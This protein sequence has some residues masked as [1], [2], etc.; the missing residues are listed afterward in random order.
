MQTFMFISRD[1]LFTIRWLYMIPAPF[2]LQKRIELSMCNV[3]KSLNVKD[4]VLIVFPLI[5]F[6][7]RIFLH[8]L[9]LFSS[10]PWIYPSCTHNFDFYAF[11]HDLF[12]KIPQILFQLK[13][14]PSFW[15]VLFFF[16]CVHFL[17]NFSSHSPT[18]NF[19]LFSLNS[20][21]IFHNWFWV[22]CPI[23]VLVGLVTFKELW[24]LF[25]RFLKTD[26]HGWKHHRLEFFLWSF[27]TIFYR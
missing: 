25:D 16:G 6:I 17:Q 18:W 23:A 5:W 11:P 8:V 1:Y 3:S 4:P 24:E 7:L 9:V 14:W 12:V 26:L 20:M 27:A 15:T 19:P 13:I 10:R 21:D 22:R 2:E